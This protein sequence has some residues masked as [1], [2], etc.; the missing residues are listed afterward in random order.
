M[1]TI[2]TWYTWYTWYHYLAPY[3]TFAQMRLYA[4]PLP[5]PLLSPLQGLVVKV[6]CTRV[7][8]IACLLGALNVIPCLP[9]ISIA[10]HACPGALVPLAWSWYGCT[11]VTC[12]TFMG[13]CLHHSHGV[14]LLSALALQSP[15]VPGPLAMPCRC[16]GLAF[17]CPCLS[18]IL[19]LSWF[20]LRIYPGLRCPHT[21]YPS[22]PLE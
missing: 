2:D 22:L 6:V 19:S 17:M 9:L 15:G 18:F 11:G 14:L 12:R 8:V 16:V 7:Y 3:H 20:A 1:Y 10:C 13:V 21:A 5:L 4:L